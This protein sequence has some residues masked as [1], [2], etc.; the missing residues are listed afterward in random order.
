MELP[1]RLLPSLPPQTQGTTPLTYPYSEDTSAPP[2][3]APDAEYPNC[4]YGTDRTDCGPHQPPPP[5]AASPPPLPAGSGFVGPTCLLWIGAFL[6]TAGLVV[7]SMG[8]FGAQLWS[9][10][11][12]GMHGRMRGLSQPG[13]APWRFRLCAFRVAGAPRHS[14]LII[15]LLLL[16][17]RGTV[18]HFCAT[19]LV[20]AAAIASADA[21]AS[22][23]ADADH[24]RQSRRRGHGGGYA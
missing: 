10:M 5:P 15:V 23:D 6:A 21:V 16:Q 3:P 9:T 12:E 4:Q 8:L 20:Q 24:P 2:A 19:L 17:L 11:P 1:H 14:M 13:G 7:R 18:G 22:A